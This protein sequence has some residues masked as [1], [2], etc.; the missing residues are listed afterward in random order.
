[1]AKFILNPEPAPRTTENL[2]AALRER[3]GDV[4]QQIIAHETLARIRAERNTAKDPKRVAELDGD[5]RFW[6][7]H[8]DEDV[9]QP[10]PVADGQA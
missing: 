2:I 3:G 8:V 10:A 5:I 6:L 4:R 9:D 1:M 7:S